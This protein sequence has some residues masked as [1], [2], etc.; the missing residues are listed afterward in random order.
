MDHRSIVDPLFIHLW[1]N[2]GPSFIYLTCTNLFGL[3]NSWHHS[4][5]SIVIKL[6][7]QS[8]MSHLSCPYSFIFV[9]TFQLV[10]QIVQ[11]FSMWHIVYCK[12]CQSKRGRQ[13]TKFW[14]ELNTLY[15]LIVVTQAPHAQFS[16]GWQYRDS[17][18]NLKLLLVLYLYFDWSLKYLRTEFINHFINCLRSVP[19]SLWYYHCIYKREWYNVIN[20][21]ILLGG[22]S[23]FMIFP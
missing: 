3:D 2:V 23:N 17:E 1:S 20:L 10:P 14:F 6:I 5:S 21:G 15:T 7:N 11:F 18:I 13:F 9:L 8:W 16:R 4:W 12:F 19:C 22:T